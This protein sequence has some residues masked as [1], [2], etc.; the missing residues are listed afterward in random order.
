MRMGNKGDI[1]LRLQQ[2]QGTPNSDGG[3]MLVDKKEE[4]ARSKR[5][6]RQHPCLT[7]SI[8][9]GASAMWK[10]AK[11]SQ[12]GASCARARRSA[13]IR[14]GTSRQ[15]QRSDPKCIVWR[16]RANAR[17]VRPTRSPTQP[18]LAGHSRPSSDAG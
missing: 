16:S 2:K 1:A 3:F 9:G 5:G 11:K 4:A 14:R 12:S 18:C 10:T 6:T 15:A 13:A 17:R 7:R 8:R